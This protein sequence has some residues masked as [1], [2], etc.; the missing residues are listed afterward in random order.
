MD[1]VA[2]LALVEQILTALPSLI[3]AGIAIDNKIEQAIAIA[4]AGQGGTPVS[5]ADLAKI[6]ADLDADLDSFN[7]P[8]A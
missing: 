6:R 5:D 7:A 1:P 4:K 3:T 8:D 2:A